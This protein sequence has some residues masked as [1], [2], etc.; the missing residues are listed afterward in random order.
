M[1]FTEIYLG[2]VSVADFRKTLGDLLAPG[3]QPLIAWDIET[4]QQ[5]GIQ[6]G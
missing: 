2:Q 3:Q 1:S 5:L 4:S 6:S